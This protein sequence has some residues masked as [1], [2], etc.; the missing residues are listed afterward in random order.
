MKSLILLTAATA[1]LALGGCQKKEEEAASEAVGAKVG[2]GS[3][4]RFIA[5]GLYR[6]GQMWTRLERPTATKN[7]APANPAAANLDDD[8]QVVVVL[9]STTGELRQC[10]NLSGHCIAMNPWSQTAQGAPALVREHA[11]DIAKAWEKAQA[12][13]DV[14]V[15]VKA[16]P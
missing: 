9:D 5:V 15:R 3:R 1:A 13:S 12:A 16:A 6:P 7:A 14:E 8:E 4:G 2:P 11:A 10:G